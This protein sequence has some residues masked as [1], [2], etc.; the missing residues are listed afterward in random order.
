MVG[1][2]IM[3]IKKN[4]LLLNFFGDYWHMNPKR[5]AASDK[6]PLIK[7]SAVE[8]WERD[9]RKLKELD[10]LGYTVVVI[11]ESDWRFNKE[12]CTKRIKDAYDRTL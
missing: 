1:V 5:F 4:D 9:A 2:A 11:W 8:I 12:T 3:S 10:E 6:H 7:K